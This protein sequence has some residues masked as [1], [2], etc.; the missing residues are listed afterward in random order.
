MFN[1]GLSHA[2][3][4]PC[5]GHRPV[6]STNPLKFADY[7][8]W[9]TYAEVDVRRRAVGSALSA[10]FASGQLKGGDYNTVGLWSANRPGM[11]LLHTAELY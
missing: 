4:K 5:L 1:L 8:V 3:D 9:Q 6:V 11:S 10:M 7:Y 2:R